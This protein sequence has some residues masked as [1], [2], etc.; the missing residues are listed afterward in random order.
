MA[1]TEVGGSYWRSQAVTFDQCKTVL[2]LA[3]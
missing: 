2:H 3:Y 1:H